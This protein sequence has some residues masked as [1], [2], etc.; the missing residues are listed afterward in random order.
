MP[1]VL[2]IRLSLRADG[3][4]PPLPLRSAQ[5]QDRL[6]WTAALRALRDEFQV[7]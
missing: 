2:A 6:G 7:R 4:Q 3:A 1:G 5:R